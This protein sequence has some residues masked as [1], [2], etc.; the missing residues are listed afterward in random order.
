MPTVLV[1]FVLLLFIVVLLLLI[2]LALL[3]VSTDRRPPL[4]VYYLSCH[5]Y[6]C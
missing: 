3:F 6:Q 1:F 4:N 5:D 2:S